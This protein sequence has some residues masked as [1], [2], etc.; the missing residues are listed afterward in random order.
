MNQPVLRRD[1]LLKW[2][3][4]PNTWLYLFLSYPL[5]DYILKHWIPIPLVSSL[6]DEGVLFVLFMFTLFHMVG[7]NRS[8]PAMKVPL[9]AFIM[10]GLAHV[11]IDMP[12][13]AANIEGFRAVYQY[14]LAFLIGFFLINHIEHA[15]NFMRFV[16]VIGAI[17]GLVGVA[18]VVIGVETPAGWTDASE[19][20]LIRAFSFVISPNVLGSYMA[21]IVPLTMGL[22]L[23]EHK[24]GMKGVW[25]LALIFTV[26][27]LLL[28]GSR[29]AWLALF[30]SVSILFVIIDRRLL[31]AGVAAA[32]AAVAFVP[33][34]R[35]RILNLFSETYFDKSLQAGRLARW[36]NAYDYMR[37]D[38]FFGKGIGHYGGAVGA[39]YFGTTYV[40]SYYFKTLAELGLIGIALFIWLMISLTRFML[41]AWQT[42]YGTKEYWLVGGLLTGLLAVILHN[43]VENIFEVPFMNSYFWF[44]SGL[45]LAFPFLKKGDSHE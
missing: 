29:G 13:L 35:I 6:W 15:V 38:P 11:V 25:L 34:V 1:N 16:A 10:L 27:A 7:S 39:R 20:G 8:V 2:P 41:K 12:Y 24:K 9:I 36:L 28:S 22:V 4:Q 30:G 5:L 23:Y 19:Q 37:Y 21:L 26:G 18:Q 33:P 42:L 32:A 45:L 44:F 14:M 40:D 17:A 31:I 43:G 3:L